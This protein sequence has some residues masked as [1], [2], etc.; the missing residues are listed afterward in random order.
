[1]R[2][3]LGTEG[4]EEGLGRSAAP[5]AR[6]L[7]RCC[8]DLSLHHSRKK[9]TSPSCGLYHHFVCGSAS[10]SA[11]TGTHEAPRDG[12]PRSHDAGSS[13]G[14]AGR[15]QTGALHALHAATWLC[16]PLRTV[17]CGCRPLHAKLGEEIVALVVAHDERWEVL[18]LHRAR[19]RFTKRPS[20]HKT[21]DTLQSAKGSCQRAATQPRPMHPP[22]TTDTGAA[23][24]RAARRL[25]R[26]ARGQQP[27][28]RANDPTARVRECRSGVRE[29]RSDAH[30]H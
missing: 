4:C 15:A 29:C 13:P 24:S 22:N 7:V 27:T 30:V 9:D 28:A 17:K 16:M 2:T 26:Q 8:A 21:T 25:P 6:G 18:D 14:R 5:T 1:M 23:C 3:R 19:R 10:I 11:A 12:A 20:L